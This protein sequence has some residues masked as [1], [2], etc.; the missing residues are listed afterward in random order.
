MD[1][2]DIILILLASK[3][4]PLVGTT[5]LQKLLFLSE[6]EKSIVP[7]EDDFN[8]QPYKYGPASKELYNDLDFLVNIGYITKSD[9]NEKLNSL[10]IDN[11]EEYGADI[12]LSESKSNSEDDEC[13]GND[14][15][16]TTDPQGPDI[17]TELREVYLSLKN[18]RQKSIKENDSIVYNITAEGLN[19]LKNNNYLQTEEYRK[20][21]DINKKYGNYSLTSLLQYVY[22]N[23]PD[24]TI[25]SEIK[26]DIL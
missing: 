17:G 11:I 12:F 25:E 2:K 10:E 1:K 15:N 3:K 5:K 14:N 22:R 26:N 24:Y 16:E 19:Y 23:Y 18:L 6:K 7:D 21:G 20:I 4:N 8:F 13:T 9:D